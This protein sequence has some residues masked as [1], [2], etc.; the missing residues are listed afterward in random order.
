MSESDNFFDARRLR[1]HAEAALAEARR[2]GATSAEVLAAVD[3]GLSVTVRLGEVETL[4]RQRDRNFAVTLYFGQRKGS[5]ATS[6]FAPESIAQTV[7][8]AADIARYTAQDPAAGLAPAERMARELPELDICHPWDLAPQEAIKLAEK[9]EAAARNADERIVNS[10][11]ASVDTGHGLAVYANTHGFIGTREGTRH[12]MSCVVVAEGEGGMQRDYWYTNARA[13]EDL[14]PAEAVGREAARRTL[15][16]LGAAPLA[17]HKTRVLF[18]PEVARGLM[19]HMLGAISGGAQYRRASFLLDA[20]G[21]RLFPEWVQML[22]RPHLPRGAGS[23]A[24]DSEGVATTDRALIENGVLNGYLLGS[25]SAR[26]LGLE[27]TGNAGGISNLVIPAGGEKPDEP[28]AALGTGFYVTELIGQGVNGV[29][30]DYSRGAAGF[31]VENGEIVHPVEEVTIA[32][33][34]RE[35]FAGILTIGADTDTRASIRTGSIL[36]DEM[37]LAGE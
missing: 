17:T 35:M 2:H 28:L 20:D 33:N 25:Y 34:L 27:T 23:R 14:D 21:E 37:A 7:A 4:E 16:R 18:A 8:S 6:D 22:E 31:R 13:P 24:F 10:E 15:A 36:I 11:G 1:E 32:G 12:D 26:R 3:D 5:A 19:G 9:T 29:T 30:G